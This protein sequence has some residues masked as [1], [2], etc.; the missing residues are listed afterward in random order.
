MTSANIDE[1]DS[2]L[3]SLAKDI[4]SDEQMCA[5]GQELDFTEGSLDRFASSNRIEGK[6]T[7]KGSTDMLFEWRQGV[8]PLELPFR[9]KKALRQ[10]GLV[11]LAEKYF[12]DI[13]QPEGKYDISMNHKL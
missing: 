10:A 9:L 4:E 3:R 8:V 13:M 7:C 1:H 11:F 2:T 5:L 6:V 12:P